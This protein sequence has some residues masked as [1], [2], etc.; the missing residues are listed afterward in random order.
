MY[1][2]SHPDTQWER[3]VSFLNSFLV[4]DK[5]TEDIDFDIDY[6]EAIGVPNNILID[7]KELVD[8]GY[9]ERAVI[10]S[11][12]LILKES[13]KGKGLSRQAKR[14]ISW[15]GKHVAPD[16]ALVEK[17]RQILNITKSSGGPFWKRLFS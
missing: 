5:A 13:P 14:I 16:Q 4:D 15:H 8:E 10:S 2:M 3:I 1:S 11:F 17:V 12:L 7:L 6:I 9:E